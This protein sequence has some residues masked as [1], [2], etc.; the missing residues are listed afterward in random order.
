MIEDLINRVANLP[1]QYI[2]A[3][4]FIMIFMENVTPFVPGDSFLAFSAYLSG[5]GLLPPLLTFSVS[6]L[7]SFTGFILVYWIGFHWGREYFEAKRLRFFTL[8]NLQQTDRYYQKYG[9]MFV[10]INRFLPGFRFLAAIFAGFTRAHYIRT[11]VYSLLSILAW[12]GLIFQMGHYLG[13]NWQEI[14]VFLKEYN[15]IAL[16][17]IG[18]LIVFLIVFV[19][20]RKSKKKELASID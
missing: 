19:L 8:K 13:K 12:N 1:I 14:V 7:G 5:T 9:D 17:I 3:V 15:L 6:I 16:I 18:I 4:L 20:T 10:L 2:L 11:F